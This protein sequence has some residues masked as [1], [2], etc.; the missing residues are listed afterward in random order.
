MFIQRANPTEE[1]KEKLKQQEIEISE[2]KELIIKGFEE[3]KKQPVRSSAAP[4]PAAPP[5]GGVAEDSE[6][7]NANANIETIDQGPD[8]PP[9]I[10]DLI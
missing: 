10:P 3:I 8:L 4:P 2:L 9:A 5:S 7:V 1:I 6:G